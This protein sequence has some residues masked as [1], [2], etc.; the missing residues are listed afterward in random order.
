[1][2]YELTEKDGYY[3]IMNRGDISGSPGRRL[4]AGTLV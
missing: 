1:M 4:P 3:T 2:D